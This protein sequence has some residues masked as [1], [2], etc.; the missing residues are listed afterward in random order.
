MNGIIGMTGVLLDTEL[1]PQQ[2]QYAEVVRSC[3]ESLLTLINDI[4]QFKRI[5]GVGEAL[6]AIAKGFQDG[7]RQTVN[8]RAN[9]EG[10]DIPIKV[11]WGSKDAI[12]PAS[13][14]SGLPAKVSVTVLDGFG[15]LVQLEAAAEVNK[16][17]A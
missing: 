8:L 11:I 6:T 1:A 16:L 3:G 13:H 12:I 10:L 4:L 5:D 9:L 14:A 7:S 17:L 15:H 2:R